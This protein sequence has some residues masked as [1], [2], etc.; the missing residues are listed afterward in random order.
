MRI[1]D[2]LILVLFLPEILWA[3]PRYSVE[4]NQSCILCHVDPAGGGARS[5]YGSQFFAYTD[6]AMKEIPFAEIEKV[7]LMLNE[8]VQIGFDA[9]TLF[10]GADQPAVNT[11]FQMQGDLYVI[12][13][14]SP[15]WTFYFDKGLYEGFEIFAMGHI[16]PYNGYLKAGHFTPP[17]GLRLADHKSFIRDKLGLGYGWTETGLEFGFHPERFSFSLAVTNGTVNPP[18]VPDADEAKA[19]TG[20][21]DFRFPI[22]EWNGWIGVTGRRNEWLGKEDLLVGG[23][24]GFSLGRFAFTGEIDTRDYLASELA[25]YAEISLKIQR[26]ITLKA[27]HDFYDPNL[28]QQT[29]AENMYVLGSEIVPNGFLQLIP[30]VR[31]HD[32]QPGSDD[33]YLEGEIQLHLFF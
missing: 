12:F 27:E 13:H 20:R 9:R 8:Q 11:F 25:T 17:Y 1:V 32:L 29:G 21:L 26:G 14:L 23:Y 24:G 16:L 22:G 10:F 4:Y 2:F 6:L 28:D 19:V 30:N 15:Q 33:D 5:L 7:Q 31:F 3:I 18:N